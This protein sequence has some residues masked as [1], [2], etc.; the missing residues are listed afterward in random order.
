MIEI[1]GK[2]QFSASH[3]LGWKILEKERRMHMVFCPCI[4]S[5]EVRAV[6][7]TQFIPQ[8]SHLT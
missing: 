4:C 6:I 7:D 3:H 1:K 5:H 2:A 8:I